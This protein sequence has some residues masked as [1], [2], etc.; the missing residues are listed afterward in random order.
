VTYAFTWVSM[1]QY[2]TM[3][4][5]PSS[6]AMVQGIMHGVYYGLGNG[7]GHLVGGLAIDEY[8]APATL[9]AMAVVIVLWLIMFFVCQKVCQ[10][11]CS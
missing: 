4:V 10:L 7:V 11:T 2:T 5:P 9:Y 8:G 6:L 1:C 3:S